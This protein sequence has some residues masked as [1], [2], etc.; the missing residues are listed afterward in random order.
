MIFKYKCVNV[1]KEFVL[2]LRG[3]HWEV[4]LDHKKEVAANSCVSEGQVKDT[5]AMYS[6]TILAYE[7]DGGFIH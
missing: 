2:T 5:G 6:H 4:S 1:F 3:G 7:G